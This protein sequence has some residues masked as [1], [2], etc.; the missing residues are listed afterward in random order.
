MNGQGWPHRRLF[1][2]LCVSL[3]GIG[4]AALL[5]PLV[6]GLLV[7]W[8]W[9]TEEPHDPDRMFL[10]VFR[11]IVLLFLLIGFLAVMRPLRDRPEDAWGLRPLEGARRRFAW[12]FLPT[13][14]L[15][16]VAIAAIVQ[17]GALTWESPLS[18]SKILRRVA[19]YLGAGVLI[20]VAEEV[21][22][23]GY[24]W[25]AWSGGRRT[26]VSAAGV[27]AVYALAHAFKPGHMNREVDL[28]AGGALEAVGQWLQAAFTPREFGPSF[29]G[30]FLFG[31]VLSGCVR[32]TG[33]LWSA[34]GVHAAGVLVVYGHG[35]FTEKTGVLS[36]WGS[37]RVFDGVLAWGLL[38]LA[39]ALLWRPLPRERTQSAPLGA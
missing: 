14:L 35:A 32:R 12:G 29:L 33:R 37:R 9:I 10:K 13:L 39:A 8:G 7:D 31:L 3:A 21:F 1:T 24:L 17:G 22:F 30:L 4:L 36:L 23:R 6:H 5:T 18:A 16:V 27:S 11:R 19:Q 2:L 28:T 38:A 20:A 15:G 25:R 34:I 26:L